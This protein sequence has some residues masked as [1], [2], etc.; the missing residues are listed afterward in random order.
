V[1]NTPFLISMHQIELSTIKE[2]QKGAIET[3]ERDIGIVGTLALE[4]LDDQASVITAEEGAPKHKRNHSNE[5]LQNVEVQ[6]RGT[7]PR[8]GPS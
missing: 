7:I 5:D 8:P 2:Y 1:K 4:A 3:G 6:V